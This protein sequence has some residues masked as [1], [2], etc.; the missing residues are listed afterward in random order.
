M[1]R[2][3]NQAAAIEGLSLGC[4]IVGHQRAAFVATI[5]TAGARSRCHFVGEGTGRQFCGAIVHRE[6]FGACLLVFCDMGLV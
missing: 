2:R 5:L 3:L 1:V 6:Q 4:R